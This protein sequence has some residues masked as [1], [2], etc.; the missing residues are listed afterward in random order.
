MCPESLYFHSYADYLYD[1][2]DYSEYMNIN[3]LLI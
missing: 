1:D 3:D 2:Y